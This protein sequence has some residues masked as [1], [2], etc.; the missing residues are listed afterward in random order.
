[1]ARTIARTRSCSG[2]TT[3]GTSHQDGVCLGPNGFRECCESATRPRIKD[4]EG[5]ACRLDGH[6]VPLRRKGP[7]LPGKAGG[8]DQDVIQ[9]PVPEVPVLGEE[10][11][12]FVQRK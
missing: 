8:A 6:D 11:I 7:C 4:E 2:A 1:M 12:E 10:E 3:T 9:R 5:E